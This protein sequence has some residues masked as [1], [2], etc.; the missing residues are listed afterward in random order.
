M[1]IQREHV[2]FAIIFL[3]LPLQL[4]L[5]NYMGSNEAS[6]TYAISKIVTQLSELKD[7]WFKLDNW[8]IWCSNML[9]DQL[10]GG[11]A[12]IDLEDPNGEC[13]AVE[14][15]K[16]RDKNGHFG[17]SPDPRETRPPAVKYRVGQVMKHAR[18]GYRGVIIGWD[19]EARAPDF[20]LKEMHKGNRG[21]SSQPNYAIL[22]DTR[23]RPVPQITYVPQENMEI[24]KHTKI[25]HPS[26]DD[27]FEHFDG[28]QYLPRPWLRAIYRRD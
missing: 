25:L 8:K 17:Q 23:D 3:S 14:V 13:P 16:Y 28:S 11:W 9:F 1:P 24:V 21:W 20:W 6:R 18:W 5:T 2:Q 12:D 15:F 19:E 7:S 22:V 27:Y 4:F 10:I 26:V